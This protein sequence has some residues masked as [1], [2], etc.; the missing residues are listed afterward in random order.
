[1]LNNIIKIFTTGSIFNNKIIIF[2]FT[3]LGSFIGQ[4]IIRITK[5]RGSLDKW[6]LLIPPFSIPPLSII[7]AYLIY[8]NKIKPG[9]GTNPF[10]IYM[11]IPA[12]LSIITNNLLEH[13]FKQTGLIGSLIKFIVNFISVFFALYMRDNEVCV[14]KSKNNKIKRVLI[15]PNIQI[16]NKENF[17]QLIRSK[18]NHLNY[19]SKYINNIINE[20]ENFEHFDPNTSE[21]TNKISFNKI[22]F[23]TIIIVGLMPLIPFIISKFSSIGNIITS[24]GTISPPMGILV[25]TIVRMGC[26]MT[27]YMFVNMYN[28]MNIK[29][30]CVKKY[31]QK[32]ILIGLILSFAINIIIETNRTSIIESD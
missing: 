4:L 24:A 5:L 31:P 29:K 6:W 2:I 14:K 10:D 20:F 21:Q 13:K 25:E 7:P 15:K 11:F 23:Q 3:L 12:I 18:S 30:S 1:M 16:N 28:G 8:T 26:I 9:Q 17:N 19:E 32:I 22:L 27:M